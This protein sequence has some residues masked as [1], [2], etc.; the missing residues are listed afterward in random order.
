[1]FIITLTLQILQPVY[2]DTNGTLGTLGKTWF[3]VSLWAHRGAVMVLA[4]NNGF[5]VFKNILITRYILALCQ[6]IGR[7]YQTH[8][9]R[10]LQQSPGY[11]QDGAL[12]AQATLCRTI[13]SKTTTLPPSSYR[14]SYANYQNCTIVQSH[15]PH[16]N[17]GT[18]VSLAPKILI[19]PVFVQVHSKSPT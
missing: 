13:S 11:L 12:Q 5:T 8:P 18:Y 7:I 17:Y 14:Q 15:L 16:S 19:F 9:N 2:S 1:M 4:N 6:R 3:P 10:G